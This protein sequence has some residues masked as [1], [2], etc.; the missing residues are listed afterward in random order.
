MYV[1]YVVYRLFWFRQFQQVQIFSMGK[2]SSRFLPPLFYVLCSIGAF[3][4][5]WNF[6]TRNLI[7]QWGQ[8]PSLYQ[9][10][11]C[12]FHSGSFIIFL[13]WWWLVSM[14]MFSKCPY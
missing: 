3:R 5:S 6:C 4:V 10:D 2:L 12:Q 11:L 1:V 13:L 8:K 9:Y 14:Y 7:K